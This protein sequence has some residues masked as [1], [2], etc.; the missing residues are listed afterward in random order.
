MKTKMRLF[1]S[2][3]MVLGMLLGAWESL[4]KKNP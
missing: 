1:G 4:F 2:L 3:L